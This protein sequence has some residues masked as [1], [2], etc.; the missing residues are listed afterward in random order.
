MALKTQSILGER[1]QGER[2]E[3][4]HR[5]LA[6]CKS[7]IPLHIVLHVYIYHYLQ[8]YHLV[9]VACRYSQ[10]GTAVACSIKEYSLHVQYSQVTTFALAMQPYYLA[11]VLTQSQNLG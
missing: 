4:G 1:Q 8:G 5:S 9:L 7:N 6:S 11:N 2:K 3:T 10:G